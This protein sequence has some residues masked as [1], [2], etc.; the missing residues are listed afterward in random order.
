MFRRQGPLIAH[1]LADV[2][3]DPA[4]IRHRSGTRLAVL[5]AVMSYPCH[6]PPYMPENWDKSPTTAG[7]AHR[8][9]LRQKG[10]LP[11]VFFV[12]WLRSNGSNNTLMPD[13]RTNLNIGGHE[14]GES[15]IA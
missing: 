15:E 11:E 6:A 1:L 4:P 8:L 12:F 3:T 9:D 10:S 5:P 7:V 14:A 13:L 2:G